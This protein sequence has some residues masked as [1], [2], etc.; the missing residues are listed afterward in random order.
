MDGYLQ[1]KDDIVHKKSLVETDFFVY[2]KISSF[3]DAKKDIEIL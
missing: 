2:Y 3:I 1:L